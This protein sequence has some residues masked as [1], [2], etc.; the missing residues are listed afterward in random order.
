MTLP[1]MIEGMIVSAPSHALHVLPRRLVRR[2]DGN[3]K[4]RRC[5]VHGQKLSQRDD[6][7]TR[8]RAPTPIPQVGQVRNRDSLVLP[9]SLYRTDR[10]FSSRAGRAAHSYD[11]Q[12]SALLG[13][14]EH[15]G[16]A[17]RGRDL[18]CDS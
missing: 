11:G 8:R 4:I 18:Q 2:P 1:S 13:V 7:E 3:I 5:H 9:K 12:G 10:G 17:V 6:E 14:G 15:D 16:G